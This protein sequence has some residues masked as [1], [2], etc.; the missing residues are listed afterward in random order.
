MFASAASL[1]LTPASACPTCFIG[2]AST[3]V[4]SFPYVVEVVT[5]EVIPHITIIP[6]VTTNTGYKTTTEG[7]LY[8]NAVTTVSDVDDLTWTVGDVTLTYPTTYLEYVGLEG[9]AAHGSQTCAQQDA[10]SAL[11][12]PAPQDDASFIYPATAQQPNGQ[13]PLQLLEYIQTLPAVSSQ[14]SGA[15][16]TA[17]APLPTVAKVYAQNAAQQTTVLKGGLEN[18]VPTA[19]HKTAVVVSHGTGKPIV[20]KK[21]KPHKKNTKRWDD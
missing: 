19:T 5:V 2:A 14:F 16:L 10:V 17:C 3:V 11:S 4:H 18:K 15:P 6:G 13:L 21:K 8:P 1:A 20:T 12:L 9:V 7:P